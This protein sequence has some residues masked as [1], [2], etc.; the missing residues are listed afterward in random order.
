MIN[1]KWVDGQLLQTN[2]KWGALKQSQRAWISEIT[3]EAH[4]AYVAEHGKLPMK[5]KK[6][7]IFDIVYD[8]VVQR[9]IWVPYHEFKQGVS[10]IIDRLNRKSPL[11][12]PDKAM[13]KNDNQ[14][15]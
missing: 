6:E 8:Q 1:H 9:N 13:D 5:K 14:A 4:A 7:V 12:Y 2:K 10:K 11:F 15:K 3:R